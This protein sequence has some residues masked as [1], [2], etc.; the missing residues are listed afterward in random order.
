MWDNSD[1]NILNITEKESIYKK[2]FITIILIITFSSEFF[3][4]VNNLNIPIIF[5]SFTFSKITILLIPS[6]VYDTSLC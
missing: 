4:S 5:Y 2:I 6:E 3:I 1:K